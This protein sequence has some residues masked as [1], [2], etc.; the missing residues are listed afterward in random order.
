L[1]SPFDSLMRAPVPSLPG[2]ARL[3]AGATRRRGG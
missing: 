3:V 2:R 1:V